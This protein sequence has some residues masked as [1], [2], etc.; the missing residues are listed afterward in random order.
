MAAIVAHW[1]RAFVLILIGLV[2]A[3]GN[4][5]VQTGDALASLG[6]GPAVR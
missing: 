5:W 3:G 1:P 4:L 6:P 2:R